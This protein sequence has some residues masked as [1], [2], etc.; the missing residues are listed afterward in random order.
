MLKRILFAINFIVFL[1]IFFNNVEGFAQ[2]GL[3]KNMEPVRIGE[4]EIFVIKDADVTMEK[5]L[6]PQL[7]K[8]P[9]YLGAFANGPLPAVDQVF[10]FK[11]DEHLVLIDTGWGEDGRIKGETLKI[12]QNNNILPEQITDIL[13]THLDGDHIGGLLKNGEMVF[14]NARL[15]ISKPEFEAWRAGKLPKRNEGTIKFANLVLD[16][17]SDKIALFDFEEE[18][19]PGIKAI[20]AIGHT[21][22]HTAFDI[23]SGNDKLTVAGDLFHI[24]QIQLNIPELNTIYDNDPDLAAKSRINLLNRAVENKAIFS[25]MHFPLISPVI[26]KENGG[27]L[28]RAPR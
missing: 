6:L 9:E 4:F 22:G 11:N 23:T 8:W 17:Y 19:L 28:M 12:L 15:W 5:N 18:I 25:G 26:K 16:K 14:P 2:N 27:F 21:P 13:L 1:S 7:D 10:L 24:W 20:S 3:I